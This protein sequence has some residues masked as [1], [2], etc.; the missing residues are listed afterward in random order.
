MT[1]GQVGPLL[2]AHPIAREQFVTEGEVITFRAGEDPRTTG[3]THVRWKRTG[4]AMADARVSL[5]GVADPLD[6]ESFKEYAD[7]SGFRSVDQWLDAIRESSGHGEVGELPGGHLY[8]V[9][10]QRPRE[11]LKEWLRSKYG[12]TT[13]DGCGER[14]APYVSAAGGSASGVQRNGLPA[15]VSWCVWDEQGPG[16]EERPDGWRFRLP[17]GGDF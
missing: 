10:F 11:P 7:R 4:K 1:G 14:V 8:R 16:P 2:L 13:C 9:T 6:D 15:G 3:D 5:L 12:L 17:E